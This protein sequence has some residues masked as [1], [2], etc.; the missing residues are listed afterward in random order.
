MVANFPFRCSYPNPRSTLG[1]G[2]RVSA[3]D[4]ALDPQEQPADEV[5]GKLLYSIFSPG[6]PYTDYSPKL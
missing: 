3:P 6:T 1:V 2:S 4:V 5:G